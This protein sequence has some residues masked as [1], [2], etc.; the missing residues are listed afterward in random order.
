MA[1][2]G[3]YNKLLSRAKKVGAWLD[4]LKFKLDA[5]TNI[6]N[7]C[8]LFLQRLEIEFL[9]LEIEIMGR[10]SQA[11]R[12]VEKQ[13]DDALAAKAASDAAAATAVQQQQVLQTSNDQL[14]R[15]N[16]TLTTQVTALQANQLDDADNADIDAVLGPATGG[17]DTTGGTGGTDTTTGTAGTDTTTGAAG[18]A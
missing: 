7:Q 4:S 2:S 1:L 11:I 15:D 14:T 5:N 12:A 9:E 18:G 6:R 8:V 17:T 13:R 3:R 10:A 16:G